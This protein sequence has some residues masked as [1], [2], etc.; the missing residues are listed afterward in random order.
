MTVRVS[1]PEFNLRE[2]LSELDVPVGNSGSQLMRADTVSEAFEHIQAGRKNL[3][4]NGDMRIAQRATT[5]NITADG[6]Y[7]VDRWHTVGNSSM[8]F[9]V[10]MSQESY[11]NTPYMPHRKSVKFRTN[12]AKNPSGSE[13]FIMRQKLESQDFFAAS[14]WGMDDAKWLTVSFWVKSNKPGIYSFQAYIGASGTGTNPSLLTSYTV[15]SRDVWEYKVIHIPPV[16]KNATAWIMNTGTAWGFMMDWHLSDSPND[17]VYPFGWGIANGGAAR[18][19]RGQTNILAAVGAYIEFTG[20]QLEVGRQ[21]TPFEYRSITEELALCQRY[22]YRIGGLSKQ[23][24]VVGNGFIG[25]NGGTKVAKVL[26]DLPVTMR[27]NPSVSVVGTDAFWAHTGSAFSDMTCH[28]T[29]NT[30]GI[31]NDASSGNQIWLDFGRSGGG[32]PDNGTA[33][34]VYTKDNNQGEILFTSEL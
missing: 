23:Y 31:W 7:T 29:S 25:Q 9:N 3:I 4:I 11:Q 17:E 33:T 34:V 15:D 21:A 2:K 27:S 28:V 24:Q 6:M 8:T 18:C 30:G 1:K 13:N 22:C 12:T 20:V 14:R 10:T 19:V 26:V 5:K 32:S 16:G